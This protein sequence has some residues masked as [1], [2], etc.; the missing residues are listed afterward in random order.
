[1]AHR[2]YVG[3]GTDRSTSTDRTHIQYAFSFW[4][5][6]T[7]TTHTP[8]VLYAPWSKVIARSNRYSETVFCT[9]SVFLPGSC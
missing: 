2:F 4:T 1:M 8:P 6:G 3:L 7:W 9:S 5:N